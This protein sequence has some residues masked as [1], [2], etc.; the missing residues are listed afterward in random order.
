[1]AVVFAVGF[2]LCISGIL[3]LVYSDLIFNHTYDV[4]WVAENAWVWVTVEVLVGAII[5]NIPT[6]KVFFQRHLETL[7]RT[8]YG[9][10]SELSHQRP[11]RLSGG[12]KWLKGPRRMSRNNAWAWQRTPS[13]AEEGEGGIPLESVKKSHSQVTSSAGRD[14]PI[15]HAR[16]ISPADFS[17]HSQEDRSDLTVDRT[18]PRRYASRALSSHPISPVS[19]TFYEQK[20]SQEQY[21]DDDHGTWLS[22]Q[23][24]AYTASKTATSGHHNEYDDGDARMAGFDPDTHALPILTEQ[25]SRSMGFRSE[26]Y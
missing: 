19:P 26:H 8:Y 25:E 14:T 18:H 16:K 17:M 12:L 5:A 3:R 20:F 23:T 4:V 2:F 9:R 6:L 21:P 13:N 10:S 24:S 22:N 11:S 15:E 1:M 7:S